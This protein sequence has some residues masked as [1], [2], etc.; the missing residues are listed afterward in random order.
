[1]VAENQQQQRAGDAGDAL[2]KDQAEL[3]FMHFILEWQEKQTYIYR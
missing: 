2:L 3:K 1:L